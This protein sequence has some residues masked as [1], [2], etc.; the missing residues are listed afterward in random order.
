MISL[1][2]AVPCSEEATTSSPDDLTAFSG[3]ALTASSLDALTAFLDL[4]ADFF[5]GSA[6]S[7]PEGSDLVFSAGSAAASAI[8]CPSGSALAVAG[9][10]SAR[11]ASDSLDLVLVL[12][13]A[14]GLLSDC[15]V[16]SVMVVVCCSMSSLLTFFVASFVRGVLLAAVI[17][18][19]PAVIA[20]SVL[21]V[22]SFSGTVL[23][24]CFTPEVSACFGS[25][26]CG[27]SALAAVAASLAAAFAVAVSAG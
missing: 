26:A 5:A 13:F 12:D 15:L 7:G 11:F 23:C 16:L 27:L 3:A 4:E 10:A 25:I 17:S 14:A 1:R 6:L 2:G 22:L 20:P 9:A 18:V 8:G 19:W 21:E 24:F